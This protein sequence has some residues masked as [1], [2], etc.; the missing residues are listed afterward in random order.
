[1]KEAEYYIHKG[2]RS[3]ELNDVDELKRCISNLMLLLST[4]DQESIQNNISGITR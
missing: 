4:S 3:I 2:K 1:M